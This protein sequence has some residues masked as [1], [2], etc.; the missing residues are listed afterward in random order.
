MGMKHLWSVSTTDDQGEQ[1]T[2]R[3]HAEGP[4]HALE[5]F[6]KLTG[7]SESAVSQAHV[8]FLEH[9]KVKK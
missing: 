5:E 8:L 7:V 4:V 3:V 1:T 6:L 2:Q 9:G